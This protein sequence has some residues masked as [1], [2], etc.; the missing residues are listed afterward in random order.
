MTAP[1][2]SGREHDISAIA[3]LGA[4]RVELRRAGLSVQDLAQDLGRSTEAVRDGVQQRV[5]EWSFYQRVLTA[6]AADR[7][8]VEHLRDAWR[9]LDAAKRT[10]PSR[11]ANVVPISRYVAEARKPEPRAVPVPDGELEASTPGEFISLLRKV[12]VRSGLTPAEI[13]ARGGIPRSTAYRF[14]NDQKNTALPTKMEQVRAFLVACGLPEPQVEKV[15]VVWCELQGGAA[16]VSV[17]APASPPVEQ[18]DPES[19]DPAVEGRQEP[20]SALH[21]RDVV[22]PLLRGLARPVL[23]MA[24]V[25]FTTAITAA[26]VIFASGWSGAQQATVVLMMALL[27]T[28]IAVSWCVGAN[29]RDDTDRWHRGPSPDGGLMVEEVVG[30]PAVIGLDDESEPHPAGS[31]RR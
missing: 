17:P 22:L 8:T 21:L 24:A 7:A 25:L 14:V 16:S 5:R 1:E 30:A 19:P 2:P 26:V 31:A 6:C 3:F 29:Q 18:A 27:F 28:M 4:V 12:Q 10:T 23:A 9:R 20:E 15:M 13:A 11:P